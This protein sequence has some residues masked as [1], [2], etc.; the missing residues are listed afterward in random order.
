MK[1]Y[2]SVH[3]SHQ[4]IYQNDD[5]AD[6]GDVFPSTE[7]HV[8]SLII[9]ALLLLPSEL[10]VQLLPNILLMTIFDANLAG[11]QSGKKLQC[12]YENQMANNFFQ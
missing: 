7:P 5:Q 6:L 2:N 9:Y 12:L 4:Y 11:R 10:L 3:T 8:S 1:M